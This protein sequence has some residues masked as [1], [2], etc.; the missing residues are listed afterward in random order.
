[1]NVLRIILISICFALA[2]IFPSSA[3]SQEMTLLEFPFAQN[4]KI[5]FQQKLTI[6]NDTPI[7]LVVISNSSERKFYIMGLSSNK[8]SILLDITYYISDTTLIFENTSRWVSLINTPSKLAIVLAD[9][10]NQ[11]GEVW[12]TDGTTIGT[13]KIQGNTL[14]GIPVGADRYNAYDSISNAYFPFKTYKQLTQIGDNLI[15]NK[16]HFVKYTQQNNVL[17]SLDLDSGVVQDII[18]EPTNT[19]MEIHRQSTSESSLIMTRNDDLN[20]FA[21]LH[22]IKIYQSNG[23]ANGT[24]LFYQQAFAFDN[25]RASA[26]QIARVTDRSDG[27]SIQFFY[28]FPIYS[29]GTAN[30]TKEFNIINLPYFCNDKDNDLFVQLGDRLIYPYCDSLNERGVASFDLATDQYRKLISGFGYVAPLNYQMSYLKTK[31]DS[32]FQGGVLYLPYSSGNLPSTFIYP[33]EMMR[34]DGTTEGTFSL[35]DEGKVDF[36][37]N[38]A[39]PV[40]HYNGYTALP[41]WSFSMVF[42][43]STATNTFKLPF[44]GATYRKLATEP[45]SFLEYGDFLIYSTKD[46]DLR[47]K[48]AL[49][50]NA[51]SVREL[52]PQISKIPNISLYYYPENSNLPTY[53]RSFQE[54]YVTSTNI[55]SAISYYEGVTDNSRPADYFIRFFSIPRNKCTSGSKPIPGLCGCGVS[56]TPVSKSDIG[57][58]AP[59]ATICRTELGPIVIDPDSV[60]TPKVGKP[61]KLKAKTTIDIQVPSNILTE[62]AKQLDVASA[63]LSQKSTLIGSSTRVSRRAKISNSLRVIRTRDDTTSPVAVKNKGKGKFQLIIRGELRNSDQLFFDYSFMASNSRKKTILESNSI[64]NG[65]LNFKRSKVK[66]IKK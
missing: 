6:I 15:N 52:D 23:N 28:N 9:G 59:R 22:T 41:N 36:G 55:Y 60:S 25:D 5:F 16:L 65:E 29:D 13:K 44:F 37:A 45:F 11:S 51:I 27:A 62:I 61:K 38:L 3:I 20:N 64:K 19:I 53:S 10:A 58:I 56:E 43:D 2:P 46:E 35:G 40:I 31:I 24:S 39:Q 48:R 34:T 4:E 12:T 42:T 26:L 17:T 7:V 47:E 8:A 57:S 33:I 30:G 21:A 63:N 50:S 1:M 49:L 18:T 14:L 32:Y 66:E 54:I